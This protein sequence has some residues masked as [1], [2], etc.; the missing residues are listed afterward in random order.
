MNDAL[1]RIDEKLSSVSWPKINAISCGN[2]GEGDLVVLSGGFE[3]RAVSYLSHLRTSG[4]TGYSVII[5]DY[6]PYYPENRTHTLESLARETVQDVE[7]LKYDRAEPT[8]IAERLLSTLSSDVTVF[9]DISAMSRLL[10]IQLVTGL[11]RTYNVRGLNIVYAEAETYPPT[12]AEAETK[13]AESNG[14]TLDGG[15]LSKGVLEIAAAPELN[16]IAMAGEAVRL[17]AFPSFDPVQLRSVV[18]ELQPSY[19]HFLHG[20]PPRPELTW[21][22]DTIRE[23]NMPSWS[24]AKHVSEDS[25]STLDYRETIDALLRIYQKHSTFDRIVVS[26]TG[27]KMQ[28]LGVGLVRAVLSDIQ[29]V[30]PTPHQ[31][32]CPTRHTMGVR[33]LYSL[34]VPLTKMRTLQ[35]T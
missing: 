11:M 22:R 14:V 34:V 26:P 33:Q 13:L 19:M 16:S 23:M 6:L 30:Y 29:I 1:D 32:T 28:V 4:A 31:F 10:I 15:F 17:V 5:I 8:G 3:E 25:V 2:L 9:L 27:S 12:E 24:G 35:A 18:D 21:R 7:I 20:T